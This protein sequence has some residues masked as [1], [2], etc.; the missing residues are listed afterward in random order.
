[1]HW[2][3]PWT[4]TG[5]PIE[6]STGPAL[7]LGRVADPFRCSG[8][9]SYGSMPMRSFTALLLTCLS[10]VAAV[11]SAAG[12]EPTPVRRRVGRLAASATARA[13]VIAVSLPT[14]SADR[15][16][17]FRPSRKKH[18]DAAPVFLIRPAKPPLQLRLLQELQ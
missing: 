18:G 5:L 9:R 7:P 10:I 11:S 15:L 2:R 8:A 16:P 6:G 4:F 17:G 3:S 14:G 13:G 12:Q 1:M